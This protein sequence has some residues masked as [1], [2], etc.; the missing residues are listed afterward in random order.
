M[1]NKIAVFAAALLAL[2]LASCAAAGRAPAGGGEY[3][4]GKYAETLRNS[5]LALDWWGAYE[6]TIPSAGGEGIGVRVE[7]GRDYTFALRYEYIGRANGVFTARGTFQWDEAG[8]AIT[9]AG[10]GGL[11]F[12]YPPFFQVG[13][14]FLRQL[15]MDGNPVEGGLGEYYVLRKVL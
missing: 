8:S 4:G 12:P 11:P 7:L 5:R 9:L 14:G 2:A 10:E 13:E 6:G 15:D 3:A 1:K